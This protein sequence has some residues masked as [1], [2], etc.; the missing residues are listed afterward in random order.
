M[1]VDLHIT[2]DMVA[3]GFV[4]TAAVIAGVKGY[5][6][7]VRGFEKAVPSVIEKIDVTRAVVSTLGSSDDLDD[8]YEDD[9][10]D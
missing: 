5:K 8:Y 1:K 6:A 7:G 3:R 10:E 9:E 2:K 4:Y